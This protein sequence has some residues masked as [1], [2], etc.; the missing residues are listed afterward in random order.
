MSNPQ[1]YQLMWRLQMATG[2]TYYALENL[3]DVYARRFPQNRRAIELL[4]I[5]VYSPGPVED[6][7]VD[8]AIELIYR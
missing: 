3:L 1:K 2:S 4:K 7:T 5:I 6:Q 8:E